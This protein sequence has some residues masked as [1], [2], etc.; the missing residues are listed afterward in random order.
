MHIVDGVL[1]TPVL[2]A[3]MLIT[4]V[5]TFLGLRGLSDEKLPQAAVL[6][7]CFFVASLI[8][9]PLGP[10]SVHLIFNGLIGLLLGWA[11]FPVVLIGLILQ[12]VF[13][14]FGGIVVLGAN[15]VNIALPAVMVGMALQSV[16][17]RLPAIVIGF[18]A[19]FFAVLLTALQVA[20]SL[21]LSGDGFLLSA[22][23]V[24]LGHLPV[25][26]IEGLVSAFAFQLLCKVRPSIANHSIGNAQGKCH[27]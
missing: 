18:L 8:H 24:V 13:F 27:E 4:V 25:A 11:A 3:G 2:A 5:G 21:S 17:H 19:G 10:S 1:A 20:L 12:A 22:K 26:V 6:S 9:I 23:L 14:G 16:M 15:C 7:A